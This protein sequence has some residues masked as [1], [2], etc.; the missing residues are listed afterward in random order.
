MP[1]TQADM[2]RI[3]IAARF[4]GP[5]NSGNG[6]YAAGLIAASIEESVAVRLAQPPPI[7]REL[8]VSALADGRWDVCDG[9][10][11]IATASRRAV[12][13]TTPRPPSHAEAVHAAQ[14]F[15]GRGNPSFAHCFVCGPARNAG[16]GLRIFPGRLPVPASAD[17]IGSASV[18]APWTPDASLADDDGC[19]RTEFVW[20]ALDCPGYFAVFDAGAFALLGELAV[21][22]ERRVRVDEPYVVI[23]WQLQLEGRKRQAGTALFDAA[24]RCCAVGVATWIEVKQ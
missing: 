24:D 1:I 11:L 2:P 14:H 9:A 10:A 15:A 13:L 17:A 8:T 5:P 3:T 21:R 12:E 4:N 6:G 23:G 18:A 19:V 20:A 16:D 7:D 22:I